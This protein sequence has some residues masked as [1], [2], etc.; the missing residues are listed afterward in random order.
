[1]PLPAHVASVPGSGAAP[2][3]YL[4]LG[5][6]QATEAAEKTGSLTAG[7]GVYLTTS[8]NYVTD[9]AGAVYIEA[10]NGMSVKGNKTITITDAGE[11]SLRAMTVGVAAS[12]S[13]KTGD[14]NI[15]LAASGDV[16]LE[17]VTGIEVTCQRLVYVVNQNLK[18][19]TQDKGSAN[20]ATQ[21]LFTMGGKNAISLIN[22]S[23]ITAFLRWEPGIFDHKFTI[24]DFA[25]VVVRGAGALNKTE[26]FGVRAFMTALFLPFKA[27]AANTIVAEDEEDMVVVDQ[28]VLNSS[29]SGAVSENNVVSVESAPI[30]S[31]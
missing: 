9:V 26:N 25:A 1:M 7:D 20:Y 24:G 29:Q 27:S 19:S 21:T 13:P 12:K 31:N 14:N 3:G 16:T 5:G 6:Y 11:T 22:N 15:S 10:G 30:S 28:S 2:L 4:R 23:E 17:A 8:A 18:I